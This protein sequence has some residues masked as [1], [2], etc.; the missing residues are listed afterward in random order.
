MVGMKYGDP[1]KIVVSMLTDY[2]QKELARNNNNK[3]A[4]SMGH[5]LAGM[6]IS[7][8]YRR[9]IAE[10]ARNLIAREFLRGILADYHVY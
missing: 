7:R 3:V 4:E 9:D 2:V 1:H 8:L 5:M 10:P 6:R